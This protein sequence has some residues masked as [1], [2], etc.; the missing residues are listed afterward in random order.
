MIGSL[1]LG[2]RKMRGLNFSRGN[3]KIPPMGPEAGKNE[4]K[5]LSSWFCTLGYPRGLWQCEQFPSM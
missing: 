4:R 2:P 5:F 3:W 1:P